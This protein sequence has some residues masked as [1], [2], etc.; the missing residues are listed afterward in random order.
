MRLAA[1]RVL[2]D[3]EVA[4]GQFVDARQRWVEPLAGG[5]DLP[6]F[7]RVEGVVADPSSLTR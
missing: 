3:G 7:E 4:D 5:A 6:W 1:G 2:A